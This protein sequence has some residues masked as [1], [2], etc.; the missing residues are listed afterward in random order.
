M[1]SRGHSLVDQLPPLHKLLPVISNLHRVSYLVFCCTKI[2]NKGCGGTSNI[3]EH[4]ISEMAYS[5]VSS[6]VSIKRKGSILNV[7]YS[8]L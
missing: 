7:N 2:L 1:R 4:E 6:I 5:I 3:E 8:A